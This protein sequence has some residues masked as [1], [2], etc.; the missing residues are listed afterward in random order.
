MRCL[1]LFY[2]EIKT[3]MHETLCRCILL[4]LSMTFVYIVARNFE[5]RYTI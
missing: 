3:D 1:N 5:D 4:F 2:N